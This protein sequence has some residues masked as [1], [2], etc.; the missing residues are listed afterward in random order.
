MVSAAK[1]C[2]L[3]GDGGVRAILSDEVAGR[4][5]LVLGNGRYCGENAVLDAEMCSRVRW[6]PR[7]R[8]VA[9]REIGRRVPE[10]LL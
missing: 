4:R 9:S 6:L 8:Q 10:C 2:I 1:W 3:A 5:G 7:K